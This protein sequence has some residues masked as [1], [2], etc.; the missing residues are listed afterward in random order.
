MN[1]LLCRYLTR[2]KD[3]S[4]LKKMDLNY[5]ITRLFPDNERQQVIRKA[6]LKGFIKETYINL[7]NAKG[8]PITLYSITPKGEELLSAYTSKEKKMKI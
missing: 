3:K 2:L 8:R 4:P 6:I 5:N 1:E 7:H